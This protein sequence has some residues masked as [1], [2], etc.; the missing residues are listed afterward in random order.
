MPEINYVRELALWPFLLCCVCDY[1]PY[2]P[3]FLTCY[4]LI[5]TNQFMFNECAQYYNNTVTIVTLDFS[6][7]LNKK[8]GYLCPGCGNTEY[9]SW[10]VCNREMSQSAPWG[11]PSGSE[12]EP[13][14]EPKTCS[15]SSPLNI[16]SIF[17]MATEIC[18]NFMTFFQGNWFYTAVNI[19]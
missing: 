9:L 17:W 10:T 6:T 5:I 8:F 19:K 11:I 4:T 3:F 14:W 7:R 18:N 1:S 2:L 16:S 12:S 15:Q 13:S